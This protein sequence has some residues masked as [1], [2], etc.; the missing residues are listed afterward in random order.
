M[1]LI[2]EYLSGEL[3]ASETLSFENRLSTEPIW[4]EKVEEIRIITL[5]IQEASL[6]QMLSTLRHEKTNNKTVS[7]KSAVW[8][9][10][11]VAASVITIVAIGTLLIFNKPKNE[12]LFAAYY[13][14]DPGLPVVMGDG[15]NSNYTLYDG[16]IDYKEG[17]YNKAI[18]KWNSIGNNNRFTDTLNY[19]IGVA[20]I[21]AGNLTE[22]I[23]NLEH[24]SEKEDSRFYEKAM[25][26]LS[27][28]YIKQKKNDAAKNLLNKISAIPEAKTLLSHLSD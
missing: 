17:N 3:S 6:E 14:N 20:N 4:K 11:L 23:K 7:M 1:Q 13:K 19:Y 28:I 25:W 8:K 24:V 16:M 26:Y 27:L 21:G 2:G 18:K 22:A 15:D 10:W 5:G 9:R 12:K